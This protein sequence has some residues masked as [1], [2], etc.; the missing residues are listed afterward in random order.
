LGLI[1]GLLVYYNSVAVNLYLDVVLVLGYYLF[2]LLFGLFCLV[3][4]WRYVLWLFG[5]VVFYLVGWLWF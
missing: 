5:I 2:S 4:C 3:F 1:F